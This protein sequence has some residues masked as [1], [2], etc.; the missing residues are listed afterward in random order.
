MP[1]G[2]NVVSERNRRSLPGPAL[3]SHKR[4]SMLPASKSPPKGQFIRVTGFEGIECTL[5]R[6]PRL[7]EGR[8]WITVVGTLW[9]GWPSCIA[10]AYI[11]CLAS[12]AT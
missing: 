11:S 10:I 12:R 4:A 2:T 1:L 7:R 8:S 6:A 9:T 3:L 5:A